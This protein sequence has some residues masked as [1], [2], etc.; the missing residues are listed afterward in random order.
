MSRNSDRYNSRT[1]VQ[2]SPIHGLGLFARDPISRDEYIGTY[3]GRPTADDDMHVLW[4]WNEDTEE[5]EG[6]EG[7]NELRF[8]NHSPDP[9]ADWDGTDLYALRDIEPGE[10][11]TFDYG[12]DD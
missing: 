12:W 3:L 6:I 2:T 4:I 1:R 7:E 8:I 10:E 5:W 9:N 11:I